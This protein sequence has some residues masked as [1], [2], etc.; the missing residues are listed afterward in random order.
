MSVFAELTGKLA[1][2]RVKL[3]LIKG[4]VG[5]NNYEEFKASTLRDGRTLYNAL[6]IYGVIKGKPWGTLHET[7][8]L[9]WGGIAGKIIH[10]AHEDDVAECKKNHKEDKVGQYGPVIDLIKG[11]VAGAGAS[12]GEPMPI[13][14]DEMHALLAKAREDAAAE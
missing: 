14:P 7:H 11:L 1:K 6:Q 12:S 9:R 3:K 10:F 8:Q 13:S 4:L 5:P 2:D